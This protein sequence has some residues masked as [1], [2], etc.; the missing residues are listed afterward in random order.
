LT[1]VPFRQILSD[2]SVF[3]WK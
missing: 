2:L 1:V 3:S